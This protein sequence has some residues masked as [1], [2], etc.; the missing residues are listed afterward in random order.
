LRSGSS[1][2][3]EVE[4]GSDELRIPS[5]SGY[6]CVGSESLQG[7]SRPFSENPKVI[8]AAKALVETVEETVATREK[9]TAER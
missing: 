3:A 4:P 5:A 2:S 6:L 1:Y 9:I 8:G 7:D